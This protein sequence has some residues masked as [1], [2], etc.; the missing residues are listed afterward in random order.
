MNGNNRISDKPGFNET[1]PMKAM[2]TKPLFA[3]SS[4]REYKQVVIN[5]RYC[6]W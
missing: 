3:V 2:K 5:F 4:L 1:A 6:L